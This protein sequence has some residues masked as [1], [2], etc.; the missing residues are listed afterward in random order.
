MN[1]VKLALASLCCL[2]CLSTAVDHEKPHVRVVLHS[3]EGY[4]EHEAFARKAIELLEKAVNS[5]A[6]HERLLAGSYLKTK[7]LNNEALFDSIM[8][9]HEGQG[10]GG[11]DGVIDLRIRTLQIDGNESNWYKRCHGNT[12]GIDGNNDGIAAICP[13]KLET[14]AAAGAFGDLA[15]HFFHEYL[16]L[17]GFDHIN[18][19]RG[20][21]WREKTFV[22]QGGF[23]VKDLINEGVVE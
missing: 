8:K 2:C 4:G 5:E 10:P 3:I 11:E 1:I 9:A 23:L 15:G 16:H 17:I 7:D 20:Q 21:T 14:W 22:Y 13:N 12:I 6:F 19:R 18:W